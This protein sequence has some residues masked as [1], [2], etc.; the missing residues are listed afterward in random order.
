MQENQEYQKAYQYCL[1]ILAQRDYPR[2]K[3]REKMK[4]RAVGRDIIE[5]VILRLDELG[6]IQENEYFRARIRGLLR[7]GYSFD[8]VVNKITFEYGFDVTSILQEL[9]EE[10]SLSDEVQKQRLMERKSSVFSEIDAEK[11]FV[12]IQKIRQKQ[13][14][15]L[16]SHGHRPLL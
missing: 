13:F 6:Y 15:I 3:L 12:E 9:W 1:R 11:D 8:G 16:F 4:L 14:R 10:E 2:A 7:K 5:Q